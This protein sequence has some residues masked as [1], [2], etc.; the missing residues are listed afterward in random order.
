MS[1]CLRDVYIKRPNG[2]F[3]TA[4]SLLSYDSMRVH[5][6]DTVKTQ[7][8][9]TTSHK[10]TIFILSSV[11]AKEN[12][13]RKYN[14][15]QIKKEN[16]TLLMSH[17]NTK[18]IK[19]NTITYHTLKGAS[20]KTKICFLPDQHTFKHCEKLHLFCAQEHK[21]EFDV[22]TNSESPMV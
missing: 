4:P 1:E 10:E 3:H 11:T 19:I 22:T 7:V 6:T 14:R 5:L 17:Q 21:C 15:N 12:R 20:L 16:K 9:Q 13:G 18:A 8:K 2:F